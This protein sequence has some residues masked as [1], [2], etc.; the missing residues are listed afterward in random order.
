[1][2]IFDIFNENKRKWLV[3]QGQPGIPQDFKNVIRDFLLKDNILLEKYCENERA[4]NT[5]DGLTRGLT[6]WE[7][8]NRISSNPEPPIK[9]TPTFREHFSEERLLSRGQQTPDWF[10]IAYPDVAYW[11]QENLESI[12]KILENRMEEF[13]TPSGVNPKFFRLLIDS[14]KSKHGKLECS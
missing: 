3:I 2:G 7:M 8:L 6:R 1:M 4:N 11:L 9:C 13:I 5:I 14:Y 12:E 10:F